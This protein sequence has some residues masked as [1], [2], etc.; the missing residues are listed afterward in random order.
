MD[1][2]LIVVNRCAVRAPVFDLMLFYPVKPQLWLEDGDL[3]ATVGSVPFKWP[4]V[5]DKKREGLA[6][7]CTFPSPMSTDTKRVQH[8]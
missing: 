5:L 8:R 2:A 1:Q 7:T 6:G 4:S 3:K